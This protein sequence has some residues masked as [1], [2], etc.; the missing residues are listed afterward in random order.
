M[1][2]AVSLYVHYYFSMLLRSVCTIQY[3]NMLA[4]ACS[5]IQSLIDLFHWKSFYASLG[6][7][8]TLLLLVAVCMFVPL[9]FLLIGVL[10]PLGRRFI[11]CFRA[12]TQ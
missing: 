3:Q 2:I 8:V 5:A 7:S 12:G 6:V 9:L 4:S 11:G 1:H 10:R